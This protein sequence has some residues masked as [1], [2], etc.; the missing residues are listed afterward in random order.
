ML[1][2]RTRSPLTVSIL[3]V[4]FLIP[5]AA[6]AAERTEP[7]AE[8][9]IPI[10]VELGD[11]IADLKQLGELRIDIDGAFD[12][13]ARAY[14]TAGELDKL[15][16]L[17]FQT[18]R[19]PDEG[20]IGL[21]RMLAEGVVQQTRAGSVPA[22]YHDYASLTSDLQAIAADHS[23]IVRLQS[24][25]QS[26]QG[27]ELWMLRITDNPDVE[28]DEPAVSYVSSM[29]GDEV[30][31]KELFVNLI[32]HLT[33]NYPADSR[34][35][36][37]VDNTEIWIMPSMNP[38]GTALGQRWNAGGVD[39]NR[40]FPDQFVDPV[41]STQG[42]E[43]ETAAMMDW[44][45]VTSTN[46]SVN[47]HG[48]TLVVNYPWDSNP[49]GASVYSPSPDENVYV[50]IS[51]AYADNNPSLFASNVSSY[52]NGITNGADWYSVNGGMQDYNYLWR[53]S[54][55]VVVE[56]IQI[57]WPPASQL[58]S[59]WDENLESLL[60]YMEQVH[61]GV[62]GVVTD[63][64]TGLPVA[65][66]ITIQGNPVPNYTD[67][68]VGDYHRIMLP[69]TYSMEVSAV[70]YT[71]VIIPEVVVQ[72]GPATR[73]DVQLEPL[74]A[75]L[76]SVSGRIEDGG[77][78]RLDPGETADLA[79]SMRNLGVTA[80]GVNATLIPTGW[81]TVISRSTA[82]YPNLSPGQIAESIAPHYEVTLDGGAP[83]GYEAGFSVFWT[84]NAGS[85]YSEPFFLE[86]TGEQCLSFNAGD[87]PV[88]I[89]D[90]QA[91]ESTLSVAAGLELTSLTATVD[92]SHTYTGELRVDLISPDGTPVLLHNR[93]GGSAN[94]IVGTY[95]IDL[96][97][98]EPL[99]RFYGESS[100]G[101]WKLR[102]NDGSFGDQGT[103]NGWSLEVCGR[104]GVPE[105][106]FYAA[107]RG[108]D[109]VS[110]DWWRYP[111][112]ESYR[113]YRSTDPTSAA[114][115]VDVTVEDGDE[116]DTT[117]KDQ[118]AA[119]LSFFLVT[120]VGAQG[121]GPKGHFGE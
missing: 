15:Q 51:R 89:L 111:G 40:D 88:A 75:T 90:H 10:R 67:P 61:Q 43:P 110:F 86:A 113:I 6:S 97:S 76:R 99:A 12:G 109:G 72:P 101:D 94:D 32:N 114:A 80:K 68:E 46:L 2:S 71:T 66:T 37:L 54:M 64:D 58:P 34:V 102:V 38:D 100:D 17:G 8:P 92:I 45:A 25:G 39:L 42:R 35:A 9:G 50:A 1:V 119:P 69:G 19:L 47:F 63:A 106:R 30:V 44:G 3:L 95:G 16:R 121:E 85:G 29:H 116:T 84:S 41:N 49:Q 57:K 96:T 5:L 70:G 26:T 24:V 108:V 21:A 93:T 81:E 103:I 74:G 22:Q 78:E 7:P 91:V 60:L 28:E 52:D 107:R 13:W 77:N 98:D 112:V 33:D 48:G 56:V 120:G 59:F 53:G 105:L 36:N 82:A 73:F 23:E 55:E 104:V 4:T 62:R 117:F 18:T 20:K 79:V 115:F 11:P 31:G 14:V 65:A 27:R 118:S 87:G 83:A